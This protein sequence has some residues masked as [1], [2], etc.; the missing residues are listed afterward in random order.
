M[1][2]GNT[3]RE[4]ADLDAFL[5]RESSLAT[6]YANLELVE[7]PPALDARILGAAGSATGAPKPA[8]A[9][10][11]GATPSAA[12]P[13]PA[14]AGRGNLEIIYPTPAKPLAEKTSP[15]K[16]SASRPPAEPAAVDDDE[17]YVPPAARPRWLMPASIAASVLVAVGI[18]FAVLDST[19]SVQNDGSAL[20]TLFAKRARARIEAGKAEAE[21][22]AV[23]EAASDELAAP[24]PPPPF[25]EFDGP[26]VRD[27]DASIALIRRELV[28]VDQ[29]E[30]AVEPS[31]SAPVAAPVAAPGAV[32][33]AGPARLAEPLV[34][35]PLELATLGASSGNATAV[36]QPRNRRL[37]KIL[38]LY[39]AG[40]PYLAEEALEIFL[41]DFA[42]D[43]IS[44][45]ILEIKTP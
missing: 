20:G 19:P 40:S 2:S 41:R 21:A 4:D 18:G 3:P 24:P 22:A 31:P 7:P 10:P 35:V 34:D 36:I 9:T 45:R 23:L 5:A 1:S 44:Q 37:T 17:E 11:A 27:L 15:A 16:P 14:K 28:M 6:D 25:F 26:Q 33:D 30:V 12:K 43:P 13:D 29:Q 42:D 39:D 8:A 38:E 32:A